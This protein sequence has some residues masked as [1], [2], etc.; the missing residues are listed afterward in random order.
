MRKRVLFVLILALVTSGLYFTQT[1]EAAVTTT[2]A[3][4]GT[5]LSSQNGPKWNY[6]VKSTNCSRSSLEPY[7][8]YT[9]DVTVSGDYTFT[10]NSSFPGVIYVYRSLY[11]PTAP[12][13]NIV[14][15]QDSSNNYVTGNSVTVSLNA[16]STPSRYIVVFSP[17]NIHNCPNCP[18]SSITPSNVEGTF[19][20][21]VSGPAAVTVLPEVST[22][23]ATAGT[24]LSPQTNYTWQYANNQSCSNL[25]GNV[26]FAAYSIQVQT[27]GNYTFTMNTSGFS[28]G[29]VHLYNNNFDPSQ[30]CLNLANLQDN[31]ENV[32]TGNSVTIPVNVF[33][34]VRMIAV[35]SP[36]TPGESGTFSASVR[37]IAPVT[38]LSDTLIITSQSSSKSV[39]SGCQQTLYVYATGPT[40]QTFQWYEGVEGNLAGSILIPGANSNTYT[41]PA[42]TGDKSY[43]VRVSHGSE[44]VDSETI[45]FKV[46]STNKTQFSGTLDTNQTWNLT[47]TLCQPT[48]T[49]VHYQ[50]TRIK[51]PVS[52]SYRI[53][54]NKAG[55]FSGG[56]AISL[57]AGPF[58]ATQPCLNFAINGTVN[59]DLVTNLFGGSEYTIVVSATTPSEASADFDASIGPEG[60]NNC[61]LPDTIEE[62]LIISGNPLDKAVTPNNTATLTFAY[63][64]G[65]GG[66]R[67]IQWYKGN[68]GDTSQPIPNATSTSYTTPMLNQLNNETTYHAYWARVSDPRAFTHADTGTA[69]VSVITPPITYTDALT[70]CD[71]QYAQVNGPVTY[72]KIFPFK[73]SVNGSYTF[74]ITANGFTP[75]V[76]LY[77]SIFIPSFPNINYY[78]P[79]NTQNLLASPNTMYLVITSTE[80][81]KFGTFTL[82]VTGPS[83]VVPSP[84]PRITTQ[85][86]DKIILRDQTT[87]MS[88]VN[89]TPGVA[90]QWFTGTCTNKTA[91]NGANASSYTTP[92]M[93]DYRDY[94]VKVSYGVMYVN[95]TI[96]RVQIR[97]EA[98]NDTYTIDEDTELNT[99]APGA[100]GNDKKADSK[101]ISPN[102]TS[103][104]LIGTG[105]VTTSTTTYKPNLNASGIDSFT[106]TVNDGTLASTPGT[107]T[108]NV[109]EINDAPERSAG[110]LHNLTLAEDSATTALQ[111]D[112]LAY[113]PGGGTYEAAQQLTYK[114]T[115]VPPSS[116]GTILLADGQTVVTAN[117]NY[118]LTQI[119]G[120]KFSPAADGFG[121]PYPFTFTVTDNGTSRGV[122][123]PRT[124]IQTLNITVTEVNEA[125]TANNDGLASAAEDSGARVIPFSALTGN[126]STG[127][128]NESSQA[129]LVKTV[130]NPIGGT[131]QIVG[132]DVLFTPTAN[133]NGAASFEYTVEDNGTTNGIAAPLASVAPATASFTIT[134]VNDVPA[135]TDDPISGIAEDS[136]IYTIP[137][138]SLIG[139]DSAGPADENGQVLVLAEI[140]NAAGGTLTSDATNLYFTPTADYNGAASFQYT[141]ID[142]GTTDGA[143]DPRTSVA[144]SVTFT[145]T[146]VNDAPMASNDSLPSIAEDSGVRT[147]PFT[148][149]IGNDSSSPQNESS[150]ALTVKT[151]SN[152][153]GGT[154]QIVG[155]DVLF[156]PTADYNG[157]ASFDYTV[158]DNGTTNGLADPLVNTAP[159]TASFSITE[160]NDAPTATDDDLP[161]IPED[162]DVRTIPFAALTG[163]DSTGPVN[164]GNQTLVVKTVSN[165][166]GGTVRINGTNVEFTPTANFNGAASFDYTVEDNGTTDGVADPKTSMTGKVTF[167]VT[168]LADTPSITPA[169]TN[170]DTQT[171][172]GLVIMK[173]A[174]DG[175][176]VTHFKI[177]GITGG[178]LY[179]TDGLTQIAENSFITEAE[180]GAGLKFTPDAD[181]N[182]P[183]G[184][185]FGFSVQA[186]TS[187]TDLDLAG[188][189]L[190]VSITI[191]EV[192]DAPTFSIGVNPTANVSNSQTVTNWV[193]AISP[194]PANESGQTLTFEMTNDNN[195]LFSSQ[196][197][198][199]LSGTLTYTP[200]V[201]ANGTATVTVLAKD[202]GGTALGGQN[203]SAPQTFVIT[204]STTGWT[205]NGASGVT[206]DESNP[207]TPTY[208]N[209]TA[210]ANSNAP[211]GTYILRYNIT[212][213]GNLTASGA[214]STRL[215]VRFRDE[216]A[217]SRVTV[218]IRG[219]S[220]DGGMVSPGTVFDS[221]TFAPGSGFQTQ[222]I[223]MPAVTFD[224]TQNT[225]WLEVTLTKDSTSNQPGFGLAQIIQ[226]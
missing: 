145:I 202:D 35:F 25:S 107:I 174:A 212:A 64:G 98:I 28:G 206:E 135:V 168:P 76:R 111:L 9:F 113:N 26:P 219:S 73:V 118:T 129:L 46:Y 38:V 156:T 199:D 143:A 11:S 223:V 86:T 178:T 146:E 170:E 45:R 132:T 69:V 172:T 147:I 112:S 153:V 61:T 97:P 122:A 55:N 92:P 99:G 164:D 43:W 87:T 22:T 201:G 60:E 215:R 53:H 155:T 84:R 154:V 12:C 130:S 186:A 33:T 72:Y 93:T 30:P 42:M 23:I 203:T 182:S 78:G 34:P 6:P 77:Q 217:G 96:A 166:V 74:N 171:A 226:Q 131:V 142:N 70:P 185:T 205:T 54:V 95:S 177:T 81:N 151:V 85:P 40:P 15:N 140:S 175:A 221:D 169:T 213:T 157:S 49:F 88:V 71:E 108:I 82:N 104:P 193:T 59:A 105:N 102:K 1:S 41:T 110:N 127:P 7:A 159:A 192:N 123:D 3:A 126:D 173:N 18:N 216:G 120:M 116:V 207:G 115:A 80:A 197:A 196:P 8:T 124:L 117:T 181:L 20:A 31:S 13:G 176:E 24:P 187:A 139:D 32:I 119:Q 208:T 67:T 138:A 180:G 158:E 141:V 16:S 100:L 21:T 63:T 2:I 128:A 83:L 29:V 191:N 106:Y 179:Q 200:A 50:T 47:T 211:A 109:L 57:Y 209:F 152:P 136:G 14:N 5:P 222:E 103:N 101:T 10:M 52:G 121:G 190:P 167:N 19:S 27:T 162:S 36:D 189:I 91:V 165:P 161:A 134:E 137:I 150:E 75:A 58:D 114:V 56:Y 214:A 148:D 89:S 133:Y 44:H 194:G 51:I 144:G 218:A 17:K 198:V 195:T 4:A 149:L 68:S 188:S 125:P 79:G 163:N 39:T 65:S 184:D 62:A 224:F 37:G 90:Y 160:V 183:A 204:V 225:Y 66:P 94:W 220:I 48:G 210:A